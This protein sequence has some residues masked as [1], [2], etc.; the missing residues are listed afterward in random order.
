MTLRSALGLWAYSQPGTVAYPLV[1]QEYGELVEALEF[2]TV[3]PGG[4]GDLA[5]LVK[6]P[7]AR[8][9]RPE[10]ALF[11]RVCLKDGPFTCFAGEW[12][13]PAIVLDSNQGE[14]VVLAALGGGIALRDDPDESTYASQTAN[15]IIAAE[16]A[17]RSAY[18]AIDP[19][20]SQVFPTNPATAFSPAYDGYHLE[21]ILHDLCFDLGDFTW[22]VW[23]HGINRDAAGFPTWQLN[24]HARDTATTGYMALADDILS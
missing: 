12:S 24:A 9:P 11:S 18:L 22:A 15:A 6:L 19:D 8:I 4:F 10:L 5:C 2:T 21:E 14:H 23:E 17:K 20:L 13:D 16:F 3:A 1:V 7:D